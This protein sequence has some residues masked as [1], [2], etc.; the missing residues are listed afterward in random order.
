MVTDPSQHVSDSLA[1]PRPQPRRVTSVSSLRNVSWNWATLFFTIVVTF[2]L[3]PFV[4]HKLGNGNYGIWILLA[5]LVGYLGVLD[6]GVRSAVT[7]YVARLHADA[8]DLDASRLLSTSLGIFAGMG[9]IAILAATVLATFVVEGFHIPATQ[10]QTARLVLLIGGLSVAAALVGGAF[11]G[12]IVALQRFDLGGKIEISIGIVRAA[13]IYFALEGGLGLLALS[14]IQLA[15]SVAR[16]IAFAILAFRLY[17]ELEIRR[18]LWDREW[19]RRIFSFSL[20][21]T[22]ITF[23][24]TLILYSDSVVIGAFLP[25]TAITFFA[26][27]AGLT[28][29]SRSLIRGISTIM[30][31]RTS[32]MEME[33]HATIA[34]PILRVARLASALILPVGITLLLR[35]GSFIGLWMGAEYAAPSGQVLQILTVALLF[36]AASQVLGASLLGLSLHKGLVPFFIAEAVVNLGLSILLVRQVGLPGI[37]WGTAIPNLVTSLVVLPLYARRTISL[38]LLEYYRQAWLRP[39]LAMVPFAVGTALIERYWLATNLL[40]YFAGVLAVLPLA[41]VGT[42][43][44]AL[45]HDE[46]SRFVRH[47]RGRAG[48]LSALWRARHA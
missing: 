33:G 19:L 42:Y 26:I 40:S 41:A 15:A 24:T 12:V 3:S 27:A 2:V 34:P 9:L 22:L 44:V 1:T 37:A 23:S 48:G 17:P 45:D 4:V 5:S 8:A 18:V 10:A 36:Y 43:L 39:F 35:G 29:H 25:A 21:S 20:A 46:R 14:V 32:A 30:T 28:D 11:G 38:P 13:A 31:P 6:F 7:R 47:V 16:T